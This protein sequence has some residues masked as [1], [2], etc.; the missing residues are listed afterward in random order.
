MSVRFCVHVYVHNQTKPFPFEFW[1]YRYT[2]SLVWCSMYCIFRSAVVT[3]KS[4]HDFWW[5]HTIF[6][7]ALNI[8]VNFCHNK[9]A[10][11]AVF[12]YN[13]HVCCS[14]VVSVSYVVNVPGHFNAFSALTLL[15]RHLDEHPACKNWMLRCWCSYVSRANCLHI[16]Q[17][18]PHTHTHPFNGPLSRT[19]PG[20]P[21]PE[22]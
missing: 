17:L 7:L 5:A 11:F 14:L 10:F 21:V 16:V 15:V 3:L 2:Q 18:M 22:R 8:F 6:V 20:E 12:N 19:T 4:S 9:L 1:L 13:Y